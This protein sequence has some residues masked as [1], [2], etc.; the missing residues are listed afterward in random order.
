[1]TEILSVPEDAKVSFVI[2]WDEAPAIGAVA[3]FTASIEGLDGY[4]Y[5]MQ[6]QRSTD[7]ENWQ[8]VDGE[9]ETQMR[10]VIT[11]ENMADLWR[12]NI[13][14]TGIR[15]TEEIPESTGETDPETTEETDPEST[16]ET[17]TES[18]PEA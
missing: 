13:T 14:V 18:L 10:Q 3:H 2:T 15:N 1:M 17:L 4:E 6:W 9:T 5:S 11:E 16:E 7:G 8:D 12:I